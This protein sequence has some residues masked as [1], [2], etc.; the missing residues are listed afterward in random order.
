MRVRVVLRRV[1][2]SVCRSEKIRL[3]AVC[4]L[5]YFG[6]ISAHG[7]PD[8][9]LLPLAHGESITFDIYFKWG[10]IMPRAGVG[11]FFVDKQADDSWNYSVIFRTLKLFDKVYPMRD[12]LSCVFSPQQQI[13]S[14][15][16][17]AD[18]NHKYDVDSLFFSFP[19]DEDSARI[20]SV[21][22]KRH[23]FRFDTTLVALGKVY[24]MT[25]GTMYLRAI[26]RLPAKPGDEFPLQI[27]IGRDIVNM[28]FH[29]IGEAVVE[30]K[31]K[32]YNT[33]YYSIDI[34][35]SA[36]SQAKAAAEIWVGNDLNS[37]PIRVRAK[38]SI[39]AAEAYFREG[40]NLKYP[41]ECMIS[42]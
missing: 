13:V 6:A 15:V 11:T 14:A 19:A 38:L 9:L 41:M 10:F 24:D 26:N 4:C 17:I 33:R 12:T 31:K 8:S 7:K 32:K 5:L 22:Y 37:V 18:E 42:R 29:Y 23:R 21:R 36:F 28:S 1:E 16:K 39:G 20:R 3:L 30:H 35:D 25:G 2:L 40:Y 34:Y 27:A